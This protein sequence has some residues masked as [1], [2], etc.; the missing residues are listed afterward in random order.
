MHPRTLKSK[1]IREQYATSPKCCAYCQ[2]PIPF[3]NRR[4]KYCSHSCAASSNNVGKRR[5]GEAPK[6]CA[7]CGELVVGKVQ[8]HRLCKS[9]AQLEQWRKTGTGGL[10]PNGTVTEWVK[11]YLRAK[12]NDRCC[13]CGWC[14]KSPFT[15]K[16]PL[17]ADHIDGNW[18]NNTEENLRLICPNCDSLTAT[19]KAL[20]RGR[21]RPQVRTKNSRGKRLDN[22]MIKSVRK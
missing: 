4:G 7:V 16:V 3:E 12:Y 1:L 8:H 15:N 22:N 19:H 6:S 2:G 13:L 5:H 18:Q 10:T 11:N 20:N 14:E 21:G 17:I 9:K